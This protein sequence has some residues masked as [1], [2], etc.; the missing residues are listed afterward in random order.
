MKIHWHAGNR[1]RLLENGE[2]YFPAVLDAIASARTEV[3][4]ETFILFLDEVGNTL[5][6]ALIDAAR[7]GV[8]VSLTVDGYGSP[9]LTPAFIGALTEAGAHVHIFG[10]AWPWL[11]VNLLRRLHRKIVV[12]DRR[13]AFVGGI[14]FSKDHLISDGPEAKQ[15]Y[16]LQ[17]EGPV[18]PDIHRDALRTVAPVLQR[19]DWRAWRRWRPAPWQRRAAP[20][21]A[22]AAADGEGARVAFL[23]RDNGQHRSDIERWYRMA[24]RSARQE[25]VIANAYFFPGFRLLRQMRRAARRGVQVHLIL[26]GQPDVAYMRTAARLLYHALARDGVHIHEYCQRPLHGKVAVFDRRWVT[27]GS[28]NLDPLSLTLN[29]EANVVVDDPVLGQALQ[30][31][32]QGLIDHHCNPAS[33][34]RASRLNMWRYL[35]GALAYHAVRLFPR[36]LPLLPQGAS[37]MRSFLP[38]GR[39]IDSPVRPAP[40]APVPA[41]TSAPAGASAAPTD[42]QR[43]PVQRAAG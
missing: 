30:A 2:E 12:V 38:A 9:G 15:D 29:L 4:I 28:S 33:V 10:P 16:A 34:A 14:N 40:A 17:I 32:L 42:V 20:P 39:V 1:L 35:L 27:V 37:R 13:V 19:L 25:V 7:R 3:L 8:R 36:W 21:P 26:Q 6:A 23:K 41:A 18:V 43:T 22:P 24:L 5:Q 31:H 11:R